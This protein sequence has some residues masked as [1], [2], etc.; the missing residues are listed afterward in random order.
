MQTITSLGPV[1]AIVFDIVGTLLNSTDSTT[2]EFHTILNDITDAETIRH[3]HFEVASR[4]E[5]RI[6]N[7]SRHAEAFALETTIRREALREVLG[8]HKVSLG[9]AQLDRLVNVG[10][11]FQAFPGVPQQL[12][13][14]AQKTTVIG[15]TN[16]TLNQ[17]AKASARAGLRWHALLVAQYAETFKPG[18]DAYA[19]VPRM[20]RIEPSTALFVAAHPW[21]LRGA[22]AAGF[23][24]VYLPRPHTDTPQDSDRFGLRVESLDELLPVLE[25]AN[26]PK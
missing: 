21:D 25:E 13:R 1:N 20:L 10:E 9:D 6:D 19:L 18:P 8:D 14:L 23:H 11:Q 5:Q 2:A 24:T 16:S 22:A 12:D 3:I 7:I 4:I 15:L 26:T 17:V